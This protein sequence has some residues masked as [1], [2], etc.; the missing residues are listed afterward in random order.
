ANPPPPNP[1]NP[2]SATNSNG[3]SRSTATSTPSPSPDGPDATH[4][5][6]AECHRQPTVIPTGAG[7]FFPELAFCA[8]ARAVEGSWQPSSNPT[9]DPSFIAD[10]PQKI[11]TFQGNLFH[12]HLVYTNKTTR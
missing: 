2:P 4:L 1:Y 12:P 3:T 10:R 9:V 7:R 11:F 6:S 5:D 8:P